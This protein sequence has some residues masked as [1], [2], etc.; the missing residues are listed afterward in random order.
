[1]GTDTSTFAKYGLG[2]SVGLLLMGYAFEAFHWYG[3]MKANP[4][5]GSI[6]GGSQWFYGLWFML[7][8]VVAFTAF[9]S[10]LQRAVQADPEE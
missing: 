7:G 3:Y 6:S 4:A 10:G 2:V 5:V 9:M 1:M 8:T